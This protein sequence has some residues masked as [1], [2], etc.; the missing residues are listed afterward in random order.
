[1][2]LNPPLTRWECPA[3]HQRDVT[4]EPGAHSRMH[5]CGAMGGLTVPMVEVGPDGLGRHAARHVLVEREDS[6]N[7]DTAPTDEHGRPIMAVRTERADGSNDCTV[8]APT[9]GVSVEMR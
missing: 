8:Y 2:I 4:T 7:G 9:A 1:M 3:C 5:P 6:L